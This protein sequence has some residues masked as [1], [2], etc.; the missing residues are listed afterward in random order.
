MALSAGVAIRSN[1]HYDRFD[2]E[3]STGGRV[4]GL[5]FDGLTLHIGHSGT[6][7]AEHIAA[8][9]R[10]VDQ[11]NL[12]RDA[13]TDRLAERHMVRLAESAKAEIPSSGTIECVRCHAPAVDCMHSPFAVSA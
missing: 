4:N 6:G 7:D 11:L 2:I 5:E 1:T 10:L 12:L 9:S 13:A 8:I 3:G